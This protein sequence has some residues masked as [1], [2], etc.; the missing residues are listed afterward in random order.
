MK[1]I[2][3]GG[4]G[5][6]GNR[7]SILLHQR[8][9]EV[10]LLSRKP[11]NNLFK[12]YLWCPERGTIDLAAFESA[13]A[14]IQLAGAGI[15][16][17]RWSPARK[18]LLINSRVE[19]TQLLKKSFEQ[20]AHPPQVFLSAAAI[21]YYGNRADGKVLTEAALSGGDFLAQCCV[22]WEASIQDWGDLDV[23]V[24]W[25]RLGL[26]LS[27]SGGALEKMK[28]PLHFFL[29]PYFGNGQQIYSWIHI[30]DVCN[31]F[32]YALEHPHIQ[33]CYNAVAPHPLSQKEF[34]KALAEAMNKRYALG[35]PIPKNILRMYFGEM[36]DV[37]LNSNNVSSKKI[38]GDGF[39]FQ[40]P[41]L[42][43]ALKNLH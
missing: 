37:L 18:S 30:D 31:M 6:I 1:I 29:N 13:Y 28:L 16:D 10:C 39:V 8:G 3:A 35:F 36:A 9:Y 5:L 7:L 22:A 34:A 2:L 25:F 42:L 32:I 23:R 15:A 19:S 20:L 41:E 40:Y 17:E 12:T 27:H 38:Q 11:E 26:I 14:V 24:A 43:P 33:G 21:G 4:T